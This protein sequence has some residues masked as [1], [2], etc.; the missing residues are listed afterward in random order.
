M[1][2]AKEFVSQLTDKDHYSL[3]YTNVQGF[4]AVNEL[5]GDQKGDL[6][7]FQTRD[8]LRKHL[9]PLIMGR[10]ES[11][12][13]ALITAD[14]HRTIQQGG[15]SLPHRAVIDGAIQELYPLHQR[16]SN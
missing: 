16:F 4:K 8:V 11:D 13:F 10:L 3:V 12:H 7:I 14:E 15:T 9:K 1:E 5:F 6:V 2:K